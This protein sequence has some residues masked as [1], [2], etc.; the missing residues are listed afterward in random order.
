MSRIIVDIQDLHH[1]AQLCVR[2]TVRQIKIIPPTEQSQWQPVMK[3]VY[4]FCWILDV[5][6]DLHVSENKVASRRKVGNED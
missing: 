5:N 6:S 1:F 3:T 4:R 2:D